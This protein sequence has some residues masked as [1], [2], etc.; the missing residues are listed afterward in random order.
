M[1]EKKNKK[2]EDLTLGAFHPTEKLQELG[3]GTVI[4]LEDYT[5]PK[6]K[7]KVKREHAGETT[8]EH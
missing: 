8:E 3:D 7:E 4:R 6:S 5:N 2:K 1:E